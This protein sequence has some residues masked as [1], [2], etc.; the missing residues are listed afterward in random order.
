MNDDLAPR[1]VRLPREARRGAIHELQRLIAEGTG[2]RAAMRILRE[3]HGVS[4]ATSHRW[5]N[6]AYA[7][8]NRSRRRMSRGS[9]LSFAVAVRRRA[10][11][12]ALE[13]QRHFVVGGALVSVPDPDA[14]TYLAAADSL[15][16]LLGLFELDGRLVLSAEIDSIMKDVV[17][18]VRA[19]V[20]DRDTL[21][22]ILKD[23]Q[24]RLDPSNSSSGRVQE[25]G[26]G[27]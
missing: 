18:S 16:Q 26:D 27:R 20:T 14:R 25:A 9:S 1:M 7:D 6:A 17:E 24:R 12:M 2:D 15:A 10:M 3:R 13:R 19:H 21:L 8:W 23:I 11:S 4:V 5:L 22:A